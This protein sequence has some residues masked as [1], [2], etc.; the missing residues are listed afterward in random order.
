MQITNVLT[1]E[2]LT[3]TEEAYIKE[4]NASLQAW[5]AAKE[6]LDIAKARELELRN[7]AVGLMAD[8]EKVGKVDNV[9]LGNGYKA[10]LKIPVNYG[11]VKDSDGKLDKSRLDKALSKIEKDGGAGELIA[12]RLVKWT[13]DLSIT[14]YKILSPKHAAIINEVLVTSKGTPTLEIVEP[15]K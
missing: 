15:K 1:G 5:Q 3:M 14:E 13:P 7:K 12:E 8:P 10:K 9:D 11:F 2:V 4:R 6:T